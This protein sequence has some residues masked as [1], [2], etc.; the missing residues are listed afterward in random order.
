MSFR[1]STSEVSTFLTCKQ[2]WMYAHHPSYNLEPRTLGIALTRGIVG[3]KALELYYEMIAHN[4]SH[5]D[6]VEAIKVYLKSQVMQELAF[7]DDAKVK[8]LGE[9][10]EILLNYLQESR[11]IIERYD[12]LGVEQLVTAP[13]PGAEHIDFAGRID[14]VLGE[15]GRRTIREA[16]PYDH[17]FCYNFW[18][19]NSLR[20]NPQLSN[21]SWVLA[22]MGYVSNK[23]IMNMIR[24]RTDAI[25][26]IKQEAVSVRPTVQGV[27]I[28]NHTEAALTI[29]ELKSKPRV[30]I[31]DGVT[32]SASKF[33]CEYCP[34]NEL[35]YT[36]SQGGNSENVIAAHY[37]P[38]SYGY[39]DSELDVS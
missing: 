9:L 29:V 13:L 23:G 30:S 2:R 25:E 27:F 16:I 34:F 15:K 3:H 39:V 10:N 6:A 31:A 18:S 36:E 20:M 7:G 17:K 5:E 11:W 21:Y 22:Q 4:E 19:D 1:V 14:L 24:H 37:R 28:Q 32:R 12:I 26:K 38:N 8:M 35:C 33:N